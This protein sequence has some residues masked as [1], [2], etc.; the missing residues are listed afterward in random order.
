MTVSC[1]NA[2]V[3]DGLYDCDININTTVTDAIMKMT[4]IMTAIRTPGSIGGSLQQPS[5]SSVGHLL[6]H[7]Q[8]RLVPIRYLA[9]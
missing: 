2:F 4:M 5:C 8:P 1:V 6:P 7:R 9:R 3:G